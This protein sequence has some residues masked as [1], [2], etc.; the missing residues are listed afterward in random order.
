MQ[1]TPN[2]NPNAVANRE[3]ILVSLVT[4]NKSVFRMVRVY[5]KKTEHGSYD[6]NNIKEAVEAVNNG[7]LSKLK[8]EAV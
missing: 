3:P 6:L 5:E 4:Y 2:N 8:A 7:T 1:P